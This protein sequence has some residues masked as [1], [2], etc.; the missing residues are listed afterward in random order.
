MQSRIQTSGDNVMNQEVLQTV[1]HD[2]RTPMTVIKG[3]LQLLLSGIM[4]NMTDEQL[5]LIQ[6]SVGPLEDL[7]L[8]TE[9][10]LQAAT[11]EQDTLQLNREPVNLDRLLN[12]TV[13]FYANPFKQRAMQLFREGNTYGTKVNMDAFWLRRVLGNLI[14][15]AYKFTPDHGKVTLHVRHKGPGLEIAVQDTGCGIPADKLKIVFDKFAQ[16]KPSRDHKAGSGLGLWICK[17]VIELHGGE[18][19]AE[20]TEG[21]GTSFILY[22][23]PSCIL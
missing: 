14:W 11:L 7:I 1:V 4:G 10:L 5:K 20:S 13:E 19:R 9:N 23:P 3:N 12:E 15:N 17:K 18:I 16:A 2:L 21:Q 8:M 6:L 22:L